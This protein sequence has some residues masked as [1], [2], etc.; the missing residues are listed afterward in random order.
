M[1]FERSKQLA[2]KKS[3]IE[4][5]KE[6]IMKSGLPLEIE[7]SEILK[8]N[9]WSVD[10]QSHYFD[11][12]HEKARQID[13]IATKS[14]R[15]KTSQFFDEIS[16]KLII[17]CKKSSKPWLFYAVEKGVDSS[18][19]TSEEL[20]FVN[21]ALYVKNWI[22]LKKEQK[23][24]T[25][26]TLTKEEMAEGL[27]IFFDQFNKLA[28]LTH[29]YNEYG[30]E[31]GLIP[32]V[33]FIKKG[34]ENGKDE[35]FEAKNQVIKALIYTTDLYQSTPNILKQSSI[36]FVYPIIVFDGKLYKCFKKRNVEIQ[37]IKYIQY[38]TTH[39]RPKKQ[40]VYLD[41]PN[42]IKEA[43]LKGADFY[44][45]EIVTKNF[46]QDFLNIIEK[47]IKSLKETDSMIL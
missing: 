17:E 13:I 39:S 42:E 5:V 11:E 12:Q 19:A 32:Y 30:K 45:I 2:S 35:L 1:K 15:S 4:R 27:R 31:I 22:K 38:K 24:Q 14:F 33:A 43:F 34:K 46:F 21:Y 7:I 6:E 25:K 36:G 3:E 26:V 40:K 47:E 44:I 28:S 23:Q 29:Y 20:A 9:G 41:T 37:Q 18:F 8:Q 10:N 16:I